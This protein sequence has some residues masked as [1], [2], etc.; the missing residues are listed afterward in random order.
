MAFAFKVEVVSAFHYDYTIEVHH[1]KTLL[2]L[3][4]LE[5]ILRLTLEMYNLKRLKYMCILK[6]SASRRYQVIL[7]IHNIIPKT[8]FIQLTYIYNVTQKCMDI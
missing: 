5:S 3:N 2:H 8:W 7:N 1:I 6:I 4:H